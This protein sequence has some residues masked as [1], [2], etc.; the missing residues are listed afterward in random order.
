MSEKKD[1]GNGL[2]GCV[3]FIIFLGLFICFPGG[4]PTFMKSLD[5]SLDKSMENMR[6][7]NERLEHLDT[8]NLNRK[9]QNNLQQ[10]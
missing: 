6:R 3:V 1:D 4:K 10:K 5:K 2:I 8:I 7:T 9:I